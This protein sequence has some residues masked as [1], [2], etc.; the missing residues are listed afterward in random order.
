MDNVFVCIGQGG[1]TVGLE[2]WT[3]LRAL[4]ASAGGEAF[5]IPPSPFSAHRIHRYRKHQQQQQ[6]KQ[7]HGCLRA[8]WADTEP[9]VLARV[10]AYA[11]AHC[12][13]DA[14]PPCVVSGRRG[15]GGNWA[16]GASDTASVDAIADKV[17]RLVE[18]SCVRASF[19]V[20]HSVAGGSGAG[21]GSAVIA[22]LRTTYP[23]HRII[24][25]ALL[26][27]NAGETPLQHYNTVLCAAVL[28]E[29]ADMVMAFAND[30]VL[31]RLETRRSMALD[32][33]RARSSRASGSGGDGVSQDV[34]YN[35]QKAAVSMAEVNSEIAVAILGV[36]LPR[37]SRNGNGGICGGVSCGGHDCGGDD[38]GRKFSHGVTGGAL[39]L[40]DTWESVVALTPAPAWKFTSCACNPLA[41][42]RVR[43]TRP[44]IPASTVASRAAKTLAAYG[45]VSLAS[46]VV[47][48]GGGGGGG[49][50]GTAANAI[51][52]AVAAA[53]TK[54]LRHV[55]WQPAPIS[56]Q[57]AGKYASWSSS[58]P[59][60]TVQTNSTSSITPLAHAVSRTA[61]MLASGAYVHWYERFGVD[62]NAIAAA[63][64]D[65]H[66]VVQDYNQLL[67]DV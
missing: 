41:D 56:S 22:C 67:L 58:V 63:S 54:H 20:L 26:P 34:G 65:V 50:G 55:D 3:Q 27:F 42:S 39:P 43:K 52:E 21:L 35:P 59:W 7:N 46:R 37:S 12:A 23:H 30:Q 51:E 44:P 49:G 57:Y 66:K 13:S 9:K 14:E 45:A 40:A 5:F 1:C 15:R 19:T 60:V 2:L 33:S 31:K 10:A 62:A 64:D 61:E 18:R 29:N 28:Q 36:L 4:P 38:C 32:A 48:R 8:V 16:Y 25:V 11:R 53:V 47:I 24:S 6:P 17:R